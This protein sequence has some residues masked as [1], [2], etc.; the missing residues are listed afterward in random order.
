MQF[1]SLRSIADSFLEHHREKI[2]LHGH[3]A[4]VLRILLALLLAF[5]LGA[6]P[7]YVVHE[8]RRTRLLEHD[9]NQLIRVNQQLVNQIERRRLQLESLHTPEGM[10]KALRDRGLIPAGARVYSI[11]NGSRGE[12]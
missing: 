2:A 10:G 5:S 9:L 1:D 6:L 7:V 8:R 4:W 12:R 11:E 3:A